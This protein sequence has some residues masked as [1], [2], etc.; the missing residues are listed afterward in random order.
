MALIVNKTAY[1]GEVVEQLLVRATTGNELVDGG[2][3]HVHPM[4][5]SK[6]TLPRVRT[7][8]KMLQ[9]RV[10]MPKSGA[11]GDSK[12]D[13]DYD[14]KYLEPQDIMAYTEF[15]PAVFEHVWRPFQPTG[16]MVFQELPHD[17]QETLLS[18]MAKV[19]D[20]ELGDYFLNCTKGT[21]AYEFFNGLITQMKNDAELT[22]VANAHQITEETVLAVMRKIV[23]SIPKALRKSKKM[24]IFMSVEDFDIYDAVITDKPF[25]GA[26]YRNMN[27]EKYKG[28]PIAV[29]ADLP[30]DVIFAAE[31]STG[32]D[33]NLWIGVNL[34]DDENAIQ[35]D[36]VANNGEL[37]FFKMLMKADTNTVYGEDIVLWDGRGVEPP[38]VEP[39]NIPIAPAA[40][41]APAALEISDIDGTVG[42]IVQATII[43]LAKAGVL[44]TPTPSENTEMTTVD[45]PTNSEN[46]KLTKAAIKRLNRNQLETFIADNK[47]SIEIKEGMTNDQLSNAII[48]ALGEDYFA[49]DTATE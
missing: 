22:P 14:E 11:G 3:A 2:Y 31:A 5:K 26:D 28:Y 20:M 9:R 24:T 21:G 33:S 35:V 16:N 19:I 4:V 1:S 7:K 8:G 42:Q 18:E 38:A 40:F 13:F 49:G 48:E 34:S 46:T 6:L 36:K 44:Q 43:E 37:Y 12:G 30:K 32:V 27:D 10:A 47:L 25:K 17:V 39:A 23:K 29:L 15:N 41:A 45:T